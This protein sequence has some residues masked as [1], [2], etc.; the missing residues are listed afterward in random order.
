MSIDEH[1]ERWRQWVLDN[2]QRNCSPLEMLKR[3]TGGAW[4]RNKA[5]Q[6]L[7]EG[8]ALLGM[9]RD[10]RKPLPAI[11]T[12]PDIRNGDGK[13]PRVVARFE[14]PHAVLLDGLLSVNECQ[15]LINYAYSKGLKRSGV[16]RS[17]TGDSIEHE[18]RT[19]SSVFFTRAETPLIDAL[20]NRLARLTGWP[21]ENGEGLQMLRYEPGQEYK[22]HFDWFNTDNPGSATH[23]KRGGQRVGTT[24]VYLAAPEAGGGTHFTSSGIEVFPNPGGA[25]FFADVDLFGEPDKRTLHAG[26][27]VIQG[28]KIV[29]TYWQREGAFR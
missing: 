3:M 8:L 21:V 12:T 27:P 18:A 16:V 1:G 23:L 26:K 28:T 29:L 5:V 14:S 15:E 20:E 13:A 19:S 7:D 24:V 10:W 17:D 6:A 22:A 25:I 9:S 11:A 2:L 4:D